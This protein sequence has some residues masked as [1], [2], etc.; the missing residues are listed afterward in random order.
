MD[1]MRRVAV[2]V[3]ACAMLSA[4]KPDGPQ[5]RVVDAGGA[6][7]APS[8]AVVL[9]DGKDTSHW[10]ARKGMPGCTVTDGALTCKTGSGSISSNEKFY[11][12]QIHL[13]F[14]IPNMPDQHGQMRGNSGVYLQGRYEIQILDS[15]QNPTYAN[16]SCG[17]LYGQEAPLVNVSRPPEQWQSYDIVF[18]APKCGADGKS[19]EQLARVTVLHNGVLVLDNVEI[20]KSGKTCL[21]EGPIVLQDHG[22]KTGIMTVMRFRNIWFRPL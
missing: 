6:G 4:Q 2:L 19:V 12:A 5:P 21:Q 22:P 15:Y 16:G 13:E 1:L 18:H 14:A 10:T 8:D 20:Q 3:L 17:A 7:Q 9:F 11:D